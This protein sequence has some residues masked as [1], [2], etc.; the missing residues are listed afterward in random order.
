IDEH[1][2]SAIELV[3]RQH[4]LPK[5]RAVDQILDAGEMADRPEVLRQ[6]ADRAA[7]RRAR[8]ASRRIE[9]VVAPR[10]GRWLDGQN[11][12]REQRRLARAVRPEKA[13]KRVIE[14]QI[15]TAPRLVAVGVSLRDS[16]ALDHA[17]SA[18]W[19]PSPRAVGRRGTSGVVAPRPAC[20]GL[21]PSASLRASYGRVRGHYD[22]AAAR[23]AAC[24]A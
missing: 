1:S 10:A 8:S 11:E 2:C 13:E 18:L 7:D 4:D 24:A 21:A 15:A 22:A 17:S 19:A 5:P 6:I 20:G 16:G 23:D 12:N 9:T 14:D 3:P